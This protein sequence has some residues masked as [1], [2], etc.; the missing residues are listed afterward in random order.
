MRLDINQLL[1]LSIEEKY[2]NQYKNT[3]HKYLE[4]YRAQNGLFEALSGAFEQE[5]VEEIDLNQIEHI[6]QA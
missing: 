2:H 6:I 4:Y 3:G 1:K 5:S